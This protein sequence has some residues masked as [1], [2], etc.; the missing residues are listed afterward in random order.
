MSLKE[1]ANGWPASMVVSHID[2]VTAA[3]PAT[4]QRRRRRRIS[5]LQDAVLATAVI[6]AVASL[7]WCL[8]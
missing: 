6:A 1:S 8:L 5:A 7:L 4:R 2:I 3:V